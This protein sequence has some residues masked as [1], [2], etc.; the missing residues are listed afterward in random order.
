MG[1]AA[2]HV[3]QNALH[4]GIDWY[5]LPCNDTRWLPSRHPQQLRGA[6]LNPR[7]ALKELLRDG[8]LA[9][10]LYGRTTTQGLRQGDGHVLHPLPQP[11]KSI[12]RVTKEV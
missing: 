11:R 10:E 2:L 8:N 5:P 1:A 12:H 4:V 3:I 7:P 9:V 6:D